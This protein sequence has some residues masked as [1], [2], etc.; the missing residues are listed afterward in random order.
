MVQFDVVSKD[1]VPP[2]PRGQTQVNIRLD[3]EQS[4]RLNALVEDVRLREKRAVSRN[5]LARDALAEY[6]DK[7]E[8]RA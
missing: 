1:E 7:M 4:A 8:K 2:N 5:S 6:L 3:T